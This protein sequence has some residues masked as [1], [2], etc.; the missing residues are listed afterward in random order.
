MKQKTNK[1]VRKMSS[2][3]EWHKLSAKDSARIPCSRVNCKLQA[4]YVQHLHWNT[5]NTKGLSFHYFCDTHT[6][7]VQATGK[8][9]LPKAV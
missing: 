5:G 3:C 1:E 8:S 9:Y 4:T 2:T 7:L 6:E